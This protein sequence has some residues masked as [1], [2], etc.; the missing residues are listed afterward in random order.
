[1]TEKQQIKHLVFATALLVLTALLITVLLNSVLRSTDRYETYM[2]CQR[3]NGT[4][5]RQ[6]KDQCGKLQ[7]QT[8]TEYLCNAT[9]TICWLEVK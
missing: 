4:A 8:H 3:A 7:A 1:M 5:Y 9:D 6:E 2:V